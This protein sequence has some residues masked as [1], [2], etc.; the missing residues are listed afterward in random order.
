[1]VEDSSKTGSWVS[2]QVNLQQLYK[3]IFN[4]E[5]PDRA[6]LAIMSDSD[7]TGVSVT[8]FF[9]YIQVGRD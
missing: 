3:E 7:N 6:A 8:A 5:C 2:H 4:R 1:M 9:D